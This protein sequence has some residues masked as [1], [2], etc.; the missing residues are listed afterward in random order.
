[1]LKQFNLPLKILQFLSILSFSCIICGSVNTYAADQDEIPKT[2]IEE[3]RLKPVTTIEGEVGDLLRQ[4]YAKG[5]AAGNVGDYYDNRDRGHSRLKMEEYPQ[6]Q[7]ITYSDED[8]KQQKDYAVQRTILHHVVFGNSSTSAPLNNGGSNVRTYYTNPGGMAFLYNQYTHNNIYIY[9]AH[10]DYW[11]RDG[12]G[13]V[14]PTNSPYLIASKGSSGSDRKYM[15]AVAQ[16]LAAFRPD[17]KKKLIE[18]GFL[19]PTIQ[20]ILRYS[21]AGNWLEYMKGGAHRTAGIGVNN[22]KMVKIAHELQIDEIPPLVQLKVIEEDEPL[23]GEDYFSPGKSIKLADTPVVIARIFRGKSFWHRMVV[24]AEA[25]FD[26]DGRDISFY[27]KVLQGNP[28]EISI[29][30][31]NQ[32]GSVVEIKIPYHH[33]QP[34]IQNGDLETNRVDIGVFVKSGKYYSAPGFITSFSLDNES[35]TYDEDEHILEIGYGMGKSVFEISDWNGFF[36]LINPETEF[37]PASILRNQFRRNEIDFINSVADEYSNAETSI[38][39]TKK[40]IEGKEGEEKKKLSKKLWKL[41]KEQETL[42]TDKRQGQ[43]YPINEL[44]LHALN[45]LIED[46]DFFNTYYADINHFFKT[47]TNDNKSG[48]T[49]AIN[50][51]ENYGI[52]KKKQDFVIEIIPMREGSGSL[53]ERLT[54]FEYAQ[55]KNLNAITLSSLFFPDI[56]RS[57]FQVNFVDQRLIT[58]KFWRDVY[59]YNQGGQLTG[60]TRYNDAGKTEFNRDGLIALEKDSLDRCIKGQT[61]E[62]IQDPPEQDRKRKQAWVNENPLKYLPGKEIWHYE[63]EN[64]SDWRGTVVRIEKL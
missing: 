24:S 11:Q 3:L 45:S 19:M 1:M 38:A 41:K 17:V 51:L 43:Q 63:Y 6:L 8:R 21:A 23:N 30:P 16:T 53:T 50:R 4:W 28:Q 29:Q 5:T 20:M 36:R 40:E 18:T 32:A 13:D 46:P 54:R 26:L 59:H 7:Q 15:N 61:V 64:D 49:E 62:Y 52:I 33:R 12:H 35:R 55:I 44:A 10:H 42:I 60:W 9:P 57:S 48:F 34:T 22:L 25:S 27:W 31:L 47:A 58:P 39:A 14:L 56:V 2:S 37:R